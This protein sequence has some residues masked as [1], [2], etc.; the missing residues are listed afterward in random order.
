MCFG[1]SGFK[2]DDTGGPNVRFGEG[3]QTEH[4]SDVAL[5]EGANLLHFGRGV[6]V[7]VAVRELDAALEQIRRVVVGIVE[8]GGDPEAKDICGVEVGVVESIDVGAYG[9]AKGV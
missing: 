4:G 1:E 2:G 7:V 5:I 9:Q 8:A 6:D 3:C